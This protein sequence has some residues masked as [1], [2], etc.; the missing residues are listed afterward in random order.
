MVW[1]VCLSLILPL[2]NPQAA[3]SLSWIDNIGTNILART[4]DWEDDA[5]YD[6]VDGDDHVDS[7]DHV[8]DDMII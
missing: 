8:D 5:D 4:G 6:H 7:H 2:I 3:V 1:C